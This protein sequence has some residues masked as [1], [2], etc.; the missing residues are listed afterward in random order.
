MISVNGNP[1][2]VE[3][4]RQSSFVC[5]DNLNRMGGARA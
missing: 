2:K 5:H 3:T 1:T 4:G